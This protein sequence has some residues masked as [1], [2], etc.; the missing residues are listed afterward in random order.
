MRAVHRGRSVISEGLLV[1]GRHTVFETGVLGHTN[2]IVTTSLYVN[3]T[4]SQIKSSRVYLEALAGSRLHVIRGYG[5]LTHI[6]LSRDDGCDQNEQ[7]TTNRENDVVVVGRAD[8]HVPIFIVIVPMNVA[9]YVLLKVGY[10]TSSCENG[11]RSNNGCRGHSR[12]YNRYEGGSTPNRGI[13]AIFV[14]SVFGRRR[15][16][17]RRFGRAGGIYYRHCPSRNVRSNGYDG[18]SRS[19]GCS[20]GSPSQREFCN[21]YTGGVFGYRRLYV[22]RAQ[23]Q[24]VKGRTHLSVFRG[25]VRFSKSFTISRL[26][27]GFPHL[28]HLVRFMN[29]HY[30]GVLVLAI[31]VLYLG[32]RPRS[33]RGGYGRRGYYNSP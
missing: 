19:R 5:T 8:Q 6:R 12:G 27:V 16:R 31:L 24:G 18:G 23:V 29:L 21:F 25:T 13:H 4:S 28:F 33:Q 11:K 1:P 9:L 32:L 22:R 15:R 26:G 14:R 30:Q 20:R 10:V 7:S 2:A 17:H 3:A